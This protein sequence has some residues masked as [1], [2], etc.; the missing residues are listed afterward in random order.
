LPFVFV[1][2]CGRCFVQDKQCDAAK[3]RSS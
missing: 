1:I 3:D 2:Q